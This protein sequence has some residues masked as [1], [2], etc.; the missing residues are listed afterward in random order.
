LGKH[1]QGTRNRFAFGENTGN[2][3]KPS[4]KERASAPF[5]TGN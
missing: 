2:E 4:K 3:F 1:S 5:E